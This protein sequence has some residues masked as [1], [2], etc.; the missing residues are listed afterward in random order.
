MHLLH[1]KA[2]IYADRQSYLHLCKNLVYYEGT[3]HIDIKYSFIRDN[4][5]TSIFYVNKIKTKANPT[6]FGTKIITLD[7]LI[8]GDSSELFFYGSFK[9]HSKWSF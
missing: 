9:M 1:F 2:V 4:V 6:N 3:K 5:A 7:K 8:K